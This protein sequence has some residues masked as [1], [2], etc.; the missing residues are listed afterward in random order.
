MGSS[1]HTEAAKMEQVI[2][3]FFAKSLHIILES[4][5]SYMSSRNYS[6]EHPLSSPSSS[7]SSSSGVRPRDKWFN[8]ALRDCPAALENFDICRHSNLEP[9]IVDVVLVHHW[10]PLNSSSPRKHYRYPFSWN[11]DQEELGSHG[12]TETVIERWIVQ[13]EGRKSRDSG[14]SGSRRSNNNTL[15]MLY[16][17]SILLLRSLYATVRL[18]PAYKVF[19]DL[20]SSG[21]ICTFTLRHRVSS[22]VEP[23]TRK[24]E[25]EM[26]RFGFSP[27]DTSS[28]RLCL[29]VVYRSSVSDVGSEP[30][31]PLS[32][33]FIPDYVGSPLADPLKRFPSLPASHG[34]PS[35]LPFSRR[36]S[37]SFDIY[38]TSP[39]SF[40]FPP[41]PT[42]SESHASISNPNSRRMN[43]PPHPPE[44]SSVHK[45]NTSFDEYCPSP[46]FTPSPSPSP[47][48]Y[49][50]GRNL[51]KVLLRS[52]SAPVSIPAAKLG[53]S[54]VM[55]NKQNLPPSPPIRGTRYG[56]PRT[57]ASTGFVQ[58]GTSVEKIFSLGKDD[59][60]K[61]SGLRV[62][63][64]SSPQVSFSRS[65]SRSFQDD[66]DDSDFPCPFDVEDDDMT[67]PG[68]RHGSFDARG[69][70]CDPVEHGGQFPIRKSHDAA[71]GALV[72]MLKKAAPLRQD[73]SVP[74]DLCPD[75]RI[76]LSQQEHIQALVIQQPSSSSFA[77]SKTTADALEELRSYQ[78]MVK[79]LLQNQ[80]NP[81]LP[82]K[83]ASGNGNCWLNSCS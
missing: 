58:T 13:Y 80:A 56:I 35:S 47:P 25:A 59:T 55:S 62:S 1:H 41:S 32:P 30:S 2:T 71:V 29:S 31:T 43:L 83:N 39:S 22:F 52:E 44:T 61:Y 19:R 4:R 67:D 28:G 34:S 40:P 70:F 11:S 68:S 15:H 63:L 17:K 37:W 54:P 21:Q 81:P 20:N 42:H 79:E 73:F 82:G 7:S 72:R 53:S 74:D 3:E 64:N 27:V 5:S 12:K 8:L 57:D 6:G 9:M 60:R 36:H 50:P 38:K 23:F 24:Q 65:S 18:L 33:Q 78:E 16:K 66:F 14:G 26:Q 76:K 69:H 49:I 51:S 77:G 45:K 10:D 48:I 46:N 75:S